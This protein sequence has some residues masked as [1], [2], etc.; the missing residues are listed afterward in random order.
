M[1]GCPRSFR[2][3][4]CALAHKHGPLSFAKMPPRKVDEFQF[5]QA[6]PLTARC[7]RPP[8]IRTTARRI[9]KQSKLTSPLLKFGWRHTSAFKR[10]THPAPGRACRFWQ[11]VRLLLIS[12]WQQLERLLPWRTLRLLLRTQR[13]QPLVA[14][15]NAHFSRQ[16]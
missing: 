2:R 12:G 7:L 10:S 9:P 15:A 1:A 6:M 4:P 8:R 14:G 16:L 11:M 13:Q 3:T 5:S